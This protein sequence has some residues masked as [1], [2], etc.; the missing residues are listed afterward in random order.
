MEKIIPF[1]K[2]KDDDILFI[3]PFCGFEFV[4]IEDV[5]QSKS[6]KDRSEIDVQLKCSCENGHN[7]WIELNHYKINTLVKIITE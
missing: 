6:D 3:C 4:H 1:I 2:E 5:I 7:Y